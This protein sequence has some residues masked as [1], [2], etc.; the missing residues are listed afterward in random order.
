MSVLK[1]RFTQEMREAATV[2]FLVYI[3]LAN[4][5]CVLTLCAQR[6]IAEML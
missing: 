4:M 3:P 2:L 6:F 5:W 1:S